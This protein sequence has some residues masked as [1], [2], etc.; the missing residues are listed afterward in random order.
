MDD[1]ID[2]DFFIDALK[3]E[4]LENVEV[5]EYR[6][7]SSSSNII[8]VRS[9]I[10]GEPFVKEICISDTKLMKIDNIKQHLATIATQIAQQ[11]ES[12]LTE[13]FR[14][15]EKVVKFDLK[16]N[17]KATCY[18]CSAEVT[19]NDLDT[20]SRPSELGHEKMKMTLLALLTEECHNMCPNSIDRRNRKL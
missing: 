16:N 20:R 19:I 3:E 10:G 15:G 18:H 13:Y 5:S 12:E 11:F 4:G 14:W 9:N 2:I 17:Y 1:N 7:V 8:R 6:D